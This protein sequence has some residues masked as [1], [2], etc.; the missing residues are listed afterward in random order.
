MAVFRFTLLTSFVSTFTLSCLDL[1]T[2]CPEEA[3]TA[4]SGD[5]IVL[6]T[7][8]LFRLM[9]IEQWVDAND[10]GSL[11]IVLFIVFVF[12][13]VKIKEWMPMTLGLW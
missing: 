3:L 10:P 11:V 6:F 9:K 7:L 8:S 12:R 4:S 2:L 13:L 1:E 5:C